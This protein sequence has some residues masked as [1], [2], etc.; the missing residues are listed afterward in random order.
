MSDLLWYMHRLRRMPAMELPY[1]L[2]HWA[3]KKRDKH[4][5]VPFIHHGRT[6]RCRI[7]GID[8]SG[9]EEAVPDVRTRIA[10]S[11][12]DVLNHRFRIFGIERDFG[13]P[14]DW[15]LDPK[16]G[17][18]WPL[19]FWGD[20]DYRDGRTI[21]GIKF[22]WELNRLQHLPLL[23]IAYQMTRDHGYKEE[24]FNQLQSW[25][26]GNPY[27][28][29]I[30]WISGIEIGIRMVNL[31]YSLRL[32][33]DER[34]D[35][36]R[37]AGLCEFVSR[38]ARHLYRY[39]SKHS[40][41]ANHAVA[42]ALGLFAAGLCFPAIEGAARWK[43]LGK[44][45]LEREVTRQIYPDGSSFEHSVPYLQFVS[46]L[47]LVYLLLCRDYGEPCSE[48]VNDRL[49]AAFSFLSG[50]TDGSGNCPR[51]GDGDDGCLLRLD[52]A[53]DGNLLS[54]LN[55][56][57]V[58]F[59]HAGWIPAGVDYDLMTFCLLG[60]DSRA[61]WERF[62]RQ[63]VR[64]HP[65]VQRFP[66]AGLIVIRSREDALFVANGGPLGLEPLGGHG[67]ADCLSFWLSVKGHPIVVDPGTYLYHSG[68]GWR[69]YFRGT[70]AHSTITV[71]GQDQ[72]PILSDFMFAA[73]YRTQ[74]V[75]FD[76]CEGRV[77]WS[78]EHDGYGRLEDPL[79][80][81]R[82]F[83]YV[84]S[85]GE[86]VVDDL[87][88][89]RG[90]HEITSLI[91]LHPDCRVSLSGCSMLVRS[92]QAELRFE[93]DR[94]WES[95]RLVRGQRE[96]LSGWYSPRFNEIHESPTVMCSASIHG[97]TRFTS[98][99]RV[100]NAEAVDLPWMARTYASGRSAAPMPLDSDPLSIG[101]HRLK[102]T[103]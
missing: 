40:S 7:P 4:S 9:V 41:C 95:I 62:K 63:P 96:P 3:K 38:S 36:G 74:Q 8:L 56:G 37:W 60:P 39:H 47:F 92:G 71:D 20:I 91:H 26:D 49:K 35:A 82:T 83:T 55:V 28:R 69:T 81:R 100:G 23:A 72:A 86:W 27:P 58:L 84:R 101:G 102:E 61:T 75:Y 34:L 50:L 65:E 19:V 6:H 1:R 18:R 79:I 42:E 44:S 21:G 87:L 85:G 54:L 97:T 24:L 68:G 88:S 77:V 29:G 93:L 90:S 32:L 2:E 52:A 33:G 66:D 12:K 48:D 59:D 99:I 25:M 10:A 43:R 11:A 73:F 53:D 80:H 57:A 64:R 14:I 5:V 51:I 16:T 70:S 17:K 78:V 98:I 67:H 30:N 94:Q 31:V 15:H 46:E 76:D 13:D 89:C 103:S 45:V 22:A